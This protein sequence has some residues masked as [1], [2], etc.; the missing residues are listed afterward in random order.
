MASAVL[1]IGRVIRKNVFLSKIKNPGTSFLRHE[2]F[3]KCPPKSAASQ[4]LMPSLSPTMSEGTIVKWYKKEGDTINAGDVLCDV[5]TD[6][7]VVSFDTE[8]EG[9]MA[10]IIKPENST[11]VK[12]GTLIAIMVEEGDDWQNVEIPAETEPPAEQTAQTSAAS[13]PS[14]S[15]APSPTTQSP[16]AV[17]QDLHAHGIGPSVRKLVEEYAVPVNKISGSGP[18]NRITK[19]DVVKYIKSNNLQRQSLSVEPVSGEITPA[20]ASTPSTGSYIPSIIPE[21]DGE[22]FIDIP[23]SGMRSTIAKRLTLSKTTIPHSY[24]TMNCNVGP[25]TK[26]RKQLKQEDV[27]VSV[28][29]FIIKS[30]ALA[31]QRV[32]QVNTVWENDSPSSLLNVDISVAVATDN[33]LIT[34]I[35]KNTPHLAVDEISATVKDLAERARANKLQLHEFQ[36]GSFTISNLGMFGIGEFSAVI[37]PPQTAIMAVGSSRV[38]LGQDG[39]PESQMTVTLSYDARVIDDAE[40][41]QFL[42]VFRDIIENPELM[43]SGRPASKRSNPLM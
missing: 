17:P 37:N 19:G 41:S 6:K 2:Q 20:V 5:Q 12:I 1:K 8:E 25:V 28:N 34:P 29:D 24:A 35:V 21:L 40:A 38:V 13:S 32:P 23:N 16:V 4:I 31:L 18:H 10:K 9:I 27:K 11:E 26:L 36:G 39:K 33:G 3:H 22:E 42:E 30:A 15:T 14:P 43:L 7:A